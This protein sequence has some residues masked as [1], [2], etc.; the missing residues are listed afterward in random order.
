MKYLLYATKL[1]K[2]VFYYHVRELKKPK[3]YTIELERIEKIYHEHKGRY[4][5]R[6][7][8]LTLKN[9]VV[10]LN[11]KTVQRLM[12]LLNLKSTVRPKKYR[13]Y[14]GDVGKAAPN[15]LKRNF[16]ATKP[17]EKWV[18]DVTEFKVNEQKVYLSPIIDLYNQEVV[19]YKVAKNARLTLV[20]EMLKK[21]LSQLGE[22]QKPLLHSDQGWQYR[23]KY[24]QK[25][26]ADN[27]I[28]QSMSRKGN[29]LDNAVAENFFGLLKSEM[30]HGY[31]FRDADGLIDKIGE[32]IEYYNTKRIKTKL[33]GLTPIEYRNQALQAA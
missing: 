15:Y 31:R 22:A 9:E 17:N 1:A 25:Q 27:G 2:N 5:Y 13:S 26:L 20:T 7:I 8:H 19:A 16:K 30:Y 6:R 11:H 18:T 3:E 23:H 12:G 32:Y 33:K 4:G 29:C 10:T 24:Y 14:R 28:K 21:G